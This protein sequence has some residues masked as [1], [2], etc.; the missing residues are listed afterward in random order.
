MKCEK[1]CTF[2]LPNPYYMIEPTADMVKMYEMCNALYPIYDTY[3]VSNFIFAALEWANNMFQDWTR[4]PSADPSESELSRESKM[5]D[6]RKK[7]VVLLVN[8]PDW[9]EPGELTYLGF[10][11]DFSEIPMIESDC[12]RGDIDY[13]DTTKYFAD[14]TQY[15]TGDNQVDGQPLVAGAKKIIKLT[16]FTRNATTGYYECSGDTPTAATLTFP[17]KYLV[18]IVVEGKVAWHKSNFKY[19]SES[20]GGNLG[21]GN[22]PWDGTKFL[23]GTT[24]S[25]GL[26]FTSTDGEHWET[27]ETDPVINMNPRPAYGDGK[28]LFVS[29]PDSLYAYKSSDGLNWNKYSVTWNGDAM[30]YG[31]GYFMHLSK[32]N[33]GKVYRAKSSNLEI[34]EVG[35]FSSIQ[36]SHNRA[37]GFCNGKWCAITWSGKFITSYDNGATWAVESLS[38]SSPGDVTGTTSEWY[39]PVYG[40]GRY[41]AICR[42]DNSGNIGSGNG[43]ENNSNS[44]IVFSRDGKTWYKDNNALGTLCGTT[45]WFRGLGFNGKR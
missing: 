14:G 3:N 5:T 32:T 33:K 40:F 36:S 16:G 11:N 6:N 20:T 10:D 15:N 25:S 29:Y 37:L 2:F 18:K 19:N 43:D 44:R 1:Q 41:W 31:N 23:T 17:Q 7:A 26:I 22:I 27:I 39:G 45:K 30:A 42:G 34:E 13:S 4:D 38:G 35:D 8:K 21:W 24:N 9:F 12:I 28:W